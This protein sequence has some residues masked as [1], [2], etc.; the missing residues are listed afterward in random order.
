MD[1]KKLSYHAY[2]YYNAKYDLT[3]SELKFARD[4]GLPSIKKGRNYL[5][6]EKDIN[7]YYA[8]KIGAQQSERNICLLR[9]AAKRA[10]ERG[11][12]LSPKTAR[13][14]F[15]KYGLTLSDLTEARENGMPYDIDNQSGKYLYR[16]EF[17]ID[18]FGEGKNGS[19]N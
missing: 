15:D 13:Y 8:G 17:I 19:K 5:Y 1:K 12:K 2:G 4:D 11:D 3:L 6:R 9:S 18:Y 10:A 14:F 7:D 16:E